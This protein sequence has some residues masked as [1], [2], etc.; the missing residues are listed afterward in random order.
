M[1]RIVVIGASAAGMM[2]AI[3]AAKQDGGAE[4][5]AVTGDRV[6]Y[7][8]PAIPALIAGFITEPAGAKIFSQETLAKHNIKMICPAEVT[9]IDPKNKTISI[10]SAGKEE[11]LPYDVVVLAAG[12]TPLIPK[13]KGSDKKGVCTFTTYEA[14]VEIIEAAK[15]AKS[16]VVIGA[17]FI[18]LEIAE[19]LMHKGL[20]VYFNVRSRI[21]RKL[22]EPD[23]SDILTAKF[24]Q[25]GLKMLPDETISEIGGADQVEYVVH[26]C[27][28]IA[29]DLVV[30]GTGMKP[31]VA[32]AEKCGIELGS[33]GAIKVDSRMETS[34]R[35]I[36]AAGDCAESPDMDTGSFV[37]SPVGSIGAFAGK[38]AGANAAGA[39]QQSKGFLRAQADDILGLQI[40]S[41]GHSTTTAKEV[42][43]KVKIHDLNVPK[44]SI[45]NSAANSFEA[46]KILTD[47]DDKIVGAQLVAKKHGSQFAW[48]LY[49]AVLESEDRKEF[50][51]RFNSPRA[52]FAEALVHAQKSAVVVETTGAEQVLAMAEKNMN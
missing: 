45:K 50:L 47:P 23:I 34:A 51:Q 29:A 19:A 46:A 12:A 8:R 2:A 11:K 52:K 30:I 24:E 14:A 32:L 1:K 3:S 26:K 41:I 27:A 18:A 35:D 13:I 42:G 22:L 25:Q 44:S 9:N 7:R 10:L 16:A 28:K 33:T 37:Y 48:Q 36:Y 43:L 20:D 40:F 6:P 4:V 49:K 39:N 21:L 15:N 17:G 5:T 31:N 38:I